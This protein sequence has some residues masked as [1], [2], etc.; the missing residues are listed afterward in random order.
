ML[1]NGIGRGKKSLL[2]RA[3][4]RKLPGGE[5][6]NPQKVRSILVRCLQIVAG[7]DEPALSGFRSG[8]GGFPQEIGQFLGEIAARQNT[9]QCRQVLMIAGTD[10]GAVVD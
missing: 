3:V 6:A 4:E 7:D 1:F 2:G 8:R 10:V 9:I 5:E